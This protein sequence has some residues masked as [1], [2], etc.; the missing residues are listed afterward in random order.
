[1]T[2]TEFITWLKKIATESKK[3]GNCLCYDDI[4]IF[5]PKWKLGNQ[6]S[7]SAGMASYILYDRDCQYTKSYY[8]RMKNRL[9]VLA[10]VK[11]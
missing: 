3:K 7:F 4:I 8:H 11:I 5:K 1:M 9:K 6:I 2:E 10:E